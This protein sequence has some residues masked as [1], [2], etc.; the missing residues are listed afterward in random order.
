M[1]PIAMV[2]MGAFFLLTIVSLV[3]LARNNKNLLDI[4][5]NKKDDDTEPVD[6]KVNSLTT[7]DKKA[8]KDI[9]KTSCID[10]IEEWQSGTVTEATVIKHEDETIK[11]LEVN[12]AKG[13]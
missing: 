1:D 4:V 5:T 11:Q 9:T 10:A 7:A 6:Q 13:V 3:Y 2:F 8:I 12:P